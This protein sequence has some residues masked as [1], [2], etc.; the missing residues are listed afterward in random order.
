M[1]TIYLLDDNRHDRD[2]V[3]ELIHSVGYKCHAYDSA[4]PFLD[5]VAQVTLGCVVLDVCMP[6][7]TG[8]VVFNEIRCRGV[9]LPVI[10][11]S[12]YADVP[13]AVRALSEGAFAFLEKPFGSHELVSYLNAA[14]KKNAKTQATHEFYRNVASRCNQLSRREQEV[15]EHIYGG[16]PNKRIA[17]ALNLSVRTVEA[18]RKSIMDKLQV[19][20][21]VGLVRLIAKYRQINEV[22][23]L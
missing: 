10:I 8:F 16:L 11:M 18:H 5:K 7:K 19:D 3:V 20:S 17:D 9:T 13:M 21:V 4:E 1:G 22:L 15:L 12:A 14:L 23:E 2:A 6:G